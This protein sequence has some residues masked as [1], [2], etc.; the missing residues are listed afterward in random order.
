LSYDV[1]TWRH[2]KSQLLKSPSTDITAATQLTVSPQEQKEDKEA[3]EQEDAELK[4]E[5]QHKTPGPGIRR[6]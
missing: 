3:D 6:E 2:S 4:V 1:L 5:V